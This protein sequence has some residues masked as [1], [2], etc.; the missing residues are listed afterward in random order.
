MWPYLRHAG[1]SLTPKARHTPLQPHVW[2]WTTGCFVK[3]QIWSS[4]LHISTDP[5]SGWGWWLPW[6]EPLPQWPHTLPLCSLLLERAKA[7]GTMSSIYPQLSEPPQLGPSLPGF[8]WQDQGPGTIPNTL[9]HSHDHKQIQSK[10]KLPSQRNRCFLPFQSQCLPHTQSLCHS[11]SRS[12]NVLSFLHLLSP[13]P[14]GPL[15]LSPG[16]LMLTLSEEE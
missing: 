9:L 3:S 1:A 7:T 4:A 10:Q 11:L 2:P 14:H 16:M 6:P 12:P 15:L 13:P 5:P 8:L